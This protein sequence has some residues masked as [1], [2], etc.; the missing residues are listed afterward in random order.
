MSVD[1]Q[2]TKQR[3]KIA[4]NFNRLS[5]AHQRYRRHTTDDRQRDDRRTGNSIQ[6]TAKNAI[7]LRAYWCSSAYLSDAGSNVHQFTD[8]AV[9]SSRCAWLLQG[10]RATSHAHR[11]K[12]TASS[13][14]NYSERY[15]TA[16]RPISGARLA[17]TSAK[18]FMFPSLFVCLSV[19]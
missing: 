11:L 15:V 16:F 19:C 1:G 14:L 7:V 8:L 5:M 4:E 13:S 9:T 6:R 18:E 17:V 12:V 10:T 3:R 2:C